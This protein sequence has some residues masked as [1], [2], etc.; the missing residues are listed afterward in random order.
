MTK[1]SLNIKLKQG[2][3]QSRFTMQFYSTQT[4]MLQSEQ[5]AVDSVI[6]AV[7][8][9]DELFVGTYCSFSCLR[10][11]LSVISTEIIYQQELF[12]QDKSIN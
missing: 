11:M 8:K 10:C 4:L 6:T 5:F 3:I 7:I 12:Q 2:C 9:K 1:S